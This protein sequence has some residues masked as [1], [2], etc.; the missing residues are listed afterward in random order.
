MC[1]SIC[2][3][4]CALCEQSSSVFK[5]TSKVR[6][7]YS[8]ANTLL[9]YID[10]VVIA[11]MR[12]HQIGKRETVVAVCCAESVFL[13]PELKISVHIRTTEVPRSVDHQLYS[14]LI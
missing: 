5:G 14:E 2:G 6:L 3:L 4:V 1:D 11:T 13:Q 12:T 8:V 7:K 9:A 10:V